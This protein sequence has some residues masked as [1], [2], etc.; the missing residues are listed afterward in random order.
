MA[1]LV[2]DVVCGTLVDPKS[3]RHEVMSQADYCF[4]SD[5]CRARFVVNPGRFLSR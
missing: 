5:E 4:C 2:K 3:A 1:D